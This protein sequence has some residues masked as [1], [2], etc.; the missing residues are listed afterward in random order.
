MALL[1]D[2]FVVPPE[3]W[4]FAT[5]GD[6]MNAKARAAEYI[7]LKGSLDGAD[8]QIEEFVRQ[9]ALRNVSIGL[10]HFYEKFRLQEE[11]LHPPPTPA[12]GG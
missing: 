5:H 11:T 9:W 10:R 1:A 3:E 12:V 7:K 4:L 8:R 6:V 2:F